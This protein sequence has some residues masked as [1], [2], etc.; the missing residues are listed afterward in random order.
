MCMEI[1]LNLLCFSICM[2]NATTFGM[3]RNTGKINAME[4]GGTFN[5]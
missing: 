3:E 5:K 2:D 4:K 1:P